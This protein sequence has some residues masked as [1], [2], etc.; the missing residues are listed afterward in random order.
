MKIVRY[1]VFTSKFIHTYVIYAVNIFTMGIFKMQ[2]V[3]DTL[4]PLSPYIGDLTYP[5]KFIPHPIHKIDN[6]QHEHENSKLNIRI[7][8]IS[9]VGHCVIFYMFLT[10]LKASKCFQFGQNDLCLY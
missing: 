5:I 7:V 8:E 4:T 1:T 2:I 10:M 9:Y 3:H 6:N